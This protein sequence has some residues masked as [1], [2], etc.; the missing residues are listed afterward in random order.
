MGIVSAPQAHP[1]ARHA[2][3]HGLAYGVAAQA[4]R[5]LVR[6]VGAAVSDASQRQIAGRGTPDADWQAWP[7]LAALP[8]VTAAELAPRGRAIIVAPH[9]DD[10]VLACGGLLQLLHA[11]GTRT[12]LLAVTDGTASHP[13]SDLLTPAALAR[14]RPQ[15]T[16]AAMQTLGLN[17]STAP[18]I[19]R[20]RLPDGQVSTHLDQLHTLLLQL[21]RPDDTV[22]VT[23]RQDGHPDHEACGLAAALA[24]RTCRAR[25]VEMP[26]WSW[27]WAAP[28][29]P[30]LPWQRACRLPL[31][32]DTLRRKQQAVQCFQ[33]QLHDDPTTGHTAIL[34]PHV[35]ARL[36]HPYEIYFT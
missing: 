5:P 10:E 34:P 9:P 23:W 30:R 14:L 33:T 3:G 7:G 27:H 12:V 15:E 2:A 11:Q 22:F 28:G 8:P 25:L 31:D 17:H 24:A 36:L 29:D 21:L 16:I 1:Q 35:L 19:M 20:A 26:V 13:G 18:Q 32:D 6:N 4:D